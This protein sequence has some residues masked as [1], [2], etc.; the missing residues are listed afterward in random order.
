MWSLDF[1][2]TKSSSFPKNIEILSYARFSSP[3]CSFA[4][5]WNRFH[6]YF[7][8]YAKIQVWCPMTPEFYRE[9]LNIKSRKR[10]VNACVCHVE[11]AS[12]S[13]F[14]NALINMSKMFQQR[15]ILKQKNDFFYQ[16]T[17][18]CCCF[19]HNVSMFDRIQFHIFK[20]SNPTI[21]WCLFFIINDV[22]VDV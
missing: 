21:N 14:I 18:A 7:F 19:R 22:F 9:Y 10:K 15:E 1:K 3:K 2:F 16:D 8:V 5:L 4:L 20:R 13:S 6:V 12:C 11:T 17:I